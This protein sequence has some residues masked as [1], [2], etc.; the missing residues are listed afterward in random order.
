MLQDTNKKSQTAELWEK[1]NFGNKDQNVKFRKLMGIKVRF[2][3]FY[4]LLKILFYFLLVFI[5]SY[6]SASTSRQHSSFLFS[7]LFIQFLYFIAS[8][9]DVLSVLVDADDPVV[10]TVG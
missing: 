10:F 2:I 8:N 6:V 9:M 4:F 1:L 5:S 7:L 3:L